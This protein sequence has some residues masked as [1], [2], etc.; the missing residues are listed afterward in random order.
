MKIAVVRAESGKVVES[1]IFEGELEE[2]VKDIARQAM[3]EWDP[4]S[5]DFIVTKDTYQLT[6]SGRPDEEML[7][8]LEEKGLVARDQSGVKVI[9]TIYYISFDTELGEDENYID[10]KMYIIA[11]LISVEFKD[12]LE[13]EAASLPSYRGGEFKPRG[14][15]EE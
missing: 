14:L 5:S 3:D 10:K 4:R 6:I 7:D 9:T 8:E 12:E 11:P 1:Y 15:R 13:F 2:I